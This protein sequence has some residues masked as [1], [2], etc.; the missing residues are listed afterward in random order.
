[1]C[2]FQLDLNLRLGLKKLKFLR[3]H[4]NHRG[5]SHILNLFVKIPNPRN[6]YSKLN[7]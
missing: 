5:K 2:N 6:I 1:M 4:Q 3:V 7:L